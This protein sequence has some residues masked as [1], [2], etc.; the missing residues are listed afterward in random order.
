[1]TARRLAP[2]IAA[3]LALGACKPVLFAQSVAPPGR[4]GWFDSKH[5]HLTVSPGVAIAFACEKFGGPCKGARATSDDPSIA[6]VVP[7]HLARLEARLEGGWSNATSMVP[8]TSFLVVAGKSGETRIHVRSSDGDRDLTVT[9][10]A[11]PVQVATTPTVAPLAGR[12]AT[13]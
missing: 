10:L 6:A 11:P 12:G 1:M 2:L 13:P 9:V 8:T 7:A 4:T 5:R 3:A